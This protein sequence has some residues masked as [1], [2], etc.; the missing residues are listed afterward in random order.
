MLKRDKKKW[1]KY[2]EYFLSST[3]VGTQET[4]EKRGRPP[5]YQKYVDTF[6]NKEN[7]S[8]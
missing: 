6:A 2:S 1:G 4:G 8:K 7:Q 3:W 5:E